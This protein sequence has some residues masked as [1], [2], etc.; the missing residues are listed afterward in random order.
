MIAVPAV[1]EMAG[2]CP[3]AVL[4]VAVLLAVAAW[5][6]VDVA[7]PDFPAD[8]PHQLVYIPPK[9][10]QP[11]RRGDGAGDAAVLPHPHRQEVG[12]LQ[13]LMLHGLEHLRV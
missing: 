2:R 8:L 12:L 13:R 6:R 4:A 10:S 5:V 3:V 7:L 1:L 11:G 9:L